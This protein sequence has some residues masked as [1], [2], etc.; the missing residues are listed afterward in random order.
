MKNR[1]QIETDLR[2]LFEDQL[3]D[4]YWAEKALVK[5]MPDV[6]EKAESQELI[7]ELTDHM[8][9]TVQQVARL[10]SVFE[11]IGVKAESE[12]CEAMEG[13]IE[14]AEDIIGPLQYDKL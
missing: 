6:V 1:A 3:R 8:E 7:D 5:A 4:I 11:T 9:I 13:L 14:E 2:E 10:E 12:K